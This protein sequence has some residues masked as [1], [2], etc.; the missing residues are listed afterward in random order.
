MNLKK[1]NKTFSQMNT[2]PVQ[3]TIGV[4]ASIAT[5][6]G[7]KSSPQFKQKRLLSRV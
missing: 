7:S 5:S 1:E 6:F 4:F 2:H 3:N